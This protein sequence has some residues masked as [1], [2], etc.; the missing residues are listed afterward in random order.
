MQ[1]AS[2][3][4]Y[5]VDCVS[6][7][8]A[9]DGLTSTTAWK[10]CPGD[11]NAE[12]VSAGTTLTSGDTVCFKGGVEYNGRIDCDWSGSAVD[13]I[14]YISGDA[15]TPA[16]GTGK[17]IIDGTDISYDT[18]SRG[19]FSVLASKDYI[20]I[21]GLTV[22]NAPE[23]EYT[24][25][26]GIS[27]GNN[28]A[29]EDCYIYGDGVGSQS[30]GGIYAEGIA[31]FTGTDTPGNIIIQNNEITAV[32]GHGVLLRKSIK[33]ITIQNNEIHDVNL[34]A[35]TAWGCVSAGNDYIEDLT[36]KGNEMYNFPAK[37]YTLIIG[38]INAIIEDNYF[39]ATGA[40]VNNFGIGITGNDTQI[41]VRN[42]LFGRSPHHLGVIY[43]ETEQGDIND[44]EIYN[45]TV[46]GYG[47]GDAYVVRYYWIAGNIR[48]VTIKNNIFDSIWPTHQW[49]VFLT[50][51]DKTGTYSD[52]NEN[53]VCNYNIYGTGF[54]SKLFNV[55][56]TEYTYAQWL[57]AEMGDTNSV[58]SQ[59][60]PSLDANGKPDNVADPV[61]DVGV[62]LSGTGFADDKDGLT[63]PQGTIWDIGAYE[64]DQ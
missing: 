4:K 40:V 3:V 63:R 32:V 28:I 9:N 23:V 2:E 19:I 6:G 1:S 27:G 12:T 46:L 7:S 53:F 14:T 43:L 50:I 11:D 31:N 47:D 54:V 22:R 35:V 15:I 48:N 36:I 5:Y 29:V 44:V 18:A 49:E 17:A 38:T 56:G 8:D 30:M 51:P 55:N 41:I 37:G 10:H 26:I 42:N 21:K 39:H 24:G 57:T 61:V 33:D 20:K 60:D 45:N 62:D 25:N 59:T 52:W 13:C 16:W 64:Y 58:G 34:D